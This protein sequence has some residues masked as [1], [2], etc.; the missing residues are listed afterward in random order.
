MLPLEEF[1]KLRDDDVIKFVVGSKEDLNLAFNVVSKLRE[2][3]CNCYV[4][5]SPVFGDIEPVEI[6]EFMKNNNM[7]NKIRFQ[8]QLHKFIWDPQ[9]RG[10]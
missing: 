3:N 10:V 6:V 1:A 4:Y 2:L 7:Q 5:L 9:K 8:L